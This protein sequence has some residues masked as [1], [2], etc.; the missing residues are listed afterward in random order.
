VNKKLYILGKLFNET[1]RID[2]WDEV[3]MN[4]VFKMYDNVTF[5]WNFFHNREIEEF[6]SIMYTKLKEF[7]G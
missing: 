3:G 6:I 4:T 2:T 1:L 5:S 7:N